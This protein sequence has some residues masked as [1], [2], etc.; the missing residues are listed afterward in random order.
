MKEVEVKILEINVNETIS[1]ILKLG[2][3]QTFEGELLSIF[4]DDENEN[5][6]KLH[7]TLRLRKIGSKTQLTFKDNVEKIDVKSSDEY[8]VEISDFEIM[9]EIL[10]R[11]GFNGNKQSKKHRISF[12]LPNVHFDID[13]MPNIPTFLEIEA[14]SKEIVYKYLELLGFNSN[15]ALTWTGKE[16]LDHYK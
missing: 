7:K 15:Q 10:T 2:A 8:E 1:K 12:S 3:K 13:T 14:E 16:V 6:K 5:F 4:F 9:H 11:L